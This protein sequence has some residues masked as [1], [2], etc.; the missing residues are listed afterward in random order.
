MIEA[1]GTLVILLGALLL[2]IGFLWFVIAAFQ[3]SVLW[4][5]GVLFVPFVHLIFLVLGWDRAKRPFF[6]QLVGLALVLFAA[7]VL[8]AAGHQRY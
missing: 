2:V 1:L 5:L 4:G 8:G 3:E 7:F 6:L